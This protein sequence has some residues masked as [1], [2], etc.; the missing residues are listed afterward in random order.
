M[1]LGDPLDPA[2]EAATLA[3]TG[4]TRRPQSRFASIE[5]RSEKPRPS[6]NRWAPAFY[7][8]SGVFGVLV[9]G[10]LWML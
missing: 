8:A 4:R 9:V 1:R 7:L 6:M 5:L 3:L 10:I 2:L